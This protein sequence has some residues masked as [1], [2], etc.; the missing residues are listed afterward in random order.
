MNAFNRLVIAAVA[1][2]VLA[3]A[4][5]ALLVATGALT[6]DGVLPDGPLREAVRR[7]AAAEGGERTAAVAVSAGVA[8][9][10]LVLL[11][12][13]IRPPRRA[14]PFVVDTT[15]LGRL[16]VERD[17][18]CRLAEKAATELREV[19]ACRTTLSPGEEGAGLVARCLVTVTAGSVVRDVAGAVQDRVREVIE[20]QA[21]LKVG[22]VT[23]RVRIGS[24]EPPPPARVV[25]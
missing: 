25:E 24:A 6:P 21:G 3:L 20:T 10:A 5:A 2:T 8:I 14:R 13:E 16:T 23:V 11:W 15:A 7:L 17:G 12:L 1:L 9:G 22:E 18:V 19:A 4:L